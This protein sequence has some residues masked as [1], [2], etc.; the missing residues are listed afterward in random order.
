MRVACNDQRDGHCV[1]CQVLQINA[2]AEACSSLITLYL[3]IDMP[4]YL[5]DILVFSS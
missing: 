3:N 5:N 2:T 4:G 1:G